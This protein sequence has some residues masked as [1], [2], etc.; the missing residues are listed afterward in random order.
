MP[1]KVADHNL[2]GQFQSRDVDSYAGNVPLTFRVGVIHCPPE[3]IPTV[4]CR[5]ETRRGWEFFSV[6]QS[7]PHCFLSGLRH[8]SGKDSCPS[9]SQQKQ[10][11]F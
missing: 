6:A 1:S 9:N 3:G 4:F 2:K 10:T 7:G 8:G 11:I 5:R